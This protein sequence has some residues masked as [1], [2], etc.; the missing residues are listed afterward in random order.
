MTL[1][2][3]ISDG[4]L[5]DTT[6]ENKGVK[7]F[8][9]Q[10]LM[11]FVIRTNNILYIELSLIS[12]RKIVRKTVIPIWIHFECLDYFNYDI[13]QLYHYLNSGFWFTRSKCGLLPYFIK[14]FKSSFH[15]DNL[16]LLIIIIIVLPTIHTQQQQQH[17]QNTFYHSLF[18]FIFWWNKIIKN[19]SGKTPEALVH[20]VRNYVKIG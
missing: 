12:L 1:Y 20:H 6:K 13:K 10:K 3:I 2:H 15:A 7:K 4:N 14:T 18:Y 19:P 5:V 8:R 16:L 11:R 9:N 17:T